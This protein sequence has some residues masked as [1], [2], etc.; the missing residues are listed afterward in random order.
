MPAIHDS[1]AAADGKVAC[2]AESFLALQNSW[3]QGEATLPQLPVMSHSREGE[4][5]QPRS[6]C[7][8]TEVVPAALAFHVPWPSYTAEQKICVQG[9]EMLANVPS[10]S[11]K[12]VGDPSQPGSHVPATVSNADA[13]GHDAWS[14]DVA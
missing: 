11:H 4:P 5:A 8:D 12:R 3:T 10:W 1:P 2:A 13:S 9:F 6:H 7:P 14:S